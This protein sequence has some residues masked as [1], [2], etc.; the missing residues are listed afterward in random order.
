[1]ENGRSSVAYVAVV[2]ISADLARL[3]QSTELQ[4]Q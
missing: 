1:M 3:L 4:V 2:R